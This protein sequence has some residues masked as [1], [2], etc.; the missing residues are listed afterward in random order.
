[1]YIEHR[2]KE[3]KIIRFFIR[4]VLGIM[5]IVFILEMLGTFCYVIIYKNKRRKTMK[6]FKG[7]MIATALSLAIWGILAALCYNIIL[8]G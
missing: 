4:I 6:A 5:S 7:I 3:N 2:D 8:R 1:M